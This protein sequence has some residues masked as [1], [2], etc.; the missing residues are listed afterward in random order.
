MG[1]PY[2]FVTLSDEEKD[3]RDDSI[4]L[5]AAVGFCSAFAPAAALLL[6]RAVARVRRASR[7]QYREVPNSPA[8]K[9]RRQSWSGGAAQ[10]WRRALW[11]MGEDVYFLGAHWGHRDEWIMGLVWTVW[12]LFLCVRGTGKDYL[13]LTKRFGAIATSQLPVQYLLSLK[14]LSP[15]G[16]FFRSSHERLN[17]YHRILGRIIYFLLILHAVFYN[18]FFIESGIWLK[19]FFAYVVFAGVVAFT[20]LHTLNGTSMAKMRE[21]SYRVFF[22]VHLTAAFL[23]PPLIFFHASSTRMYV[24]LAL[25]FLVLDLAARKIVT[26]TAPAIIESIP[27][28]DLLKISA[29]MPSKNI[30]KFKAHPGAHLY[31]NLP[32]ASRPN[33]DPLSTG[34]LLFEFLYNPFTV[35]SANEE[36]GDLTFVVRKRSGPMTTR[37]A[38]FAAAGVPST[39]EGRIPLCIEGPYG[40]VG[41]TFPDLVGSGISRILLVAGGVG[42][43]FAVPIYHAILADTPSARIQF[44]WAVH[45]PGDATWAP[46]DSTGKSLMDDDQVQLF[47][48]GDMG[49]SSTRD[50]AGGDI[51]LDSRPQHNVKRPNFQKIIDDIFKTGTNEKVAV[52]VCGPVQMGRELRRCLTPWVMKGRDVWWHNENFGW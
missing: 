25:G 42:A 21:Q 9:A 16:Y 28:T 40:A 38:E 44:V 48:T 43:S 41:K 36:S 6:V 15:F 18:V 8:I 24:S 13:H 31:L 10:R 3:L 49:V 27:G 29:S 19:R 23:V 47:L 1:W 26:V 11:W 32:P 14:Y 22:V 20:L 4:A 52:L 12:L 46:S 2:E 30:L 51:Q 39:P 35:V 7:G 5:H 37:L 50:T 45:S 34:N 33:P 17:R